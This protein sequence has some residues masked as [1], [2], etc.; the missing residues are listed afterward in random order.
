MS[1]AKEQL[2][3]ACTN[4]DT[5]RLRELLQAPA[6]ADNI[7]TSRPKD[8]VQ[9][10]PS[11]T[12]E[13]LAK[14]CQF[15]NIETVQLIL[16][17][18][19]KTNVTEEVI[20]HVITTKSILLYDTLRRHDPNIV[21]M[22]IYDGRESQLGRALSTPTTPEYIEFLLSSGVN[23]N[24]HID[25]DAISPLCLVALPWQS[26]SIEFC[27]ILIRYDA[28]LRGSGTLA[29][30]AM[31]GQKDLVEFLL[32]QGAD[33]NDVVLESGFG[34]KWPPL[35]AAVEA[36]QSDVVLIFL[37]QGADCD[38]LDEK[39]RTALAIAEAK[40]DAKMIDLLQ[41]YRSNR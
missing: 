34:H 3:A 6:T 14:A 39:K 2:L 23:P 30:A 16:Q 27:T 7:K 19:P 12:D 11:V 9:L 1:I 37:N 32:K 25:S 10:D 38:I 36:G 8:L 31:H 13:M 15:N 33:V 40:G 20:R 26:R 18:Y 21:Q 17:T 28:K 29:A 5:S 22:T 35:H 41:N 24:P 4:D